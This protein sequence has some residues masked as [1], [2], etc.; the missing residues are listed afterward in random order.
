MAFAA[1]VVSSFNKDAT[2]KDLVMVNKC[3]KLFKCN[4]LVFSF[5]QIN[6][7]QNIS[8][9]CFNDASFANLQI[10]HKQI[11]PIRNVTDSKSLHD[12]VYS[13]KTLTKK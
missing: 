13:T 3:I 7:L 6:D 11:L 8:L 2:V 12:T 5:P 4:E 9:V 10:A 1:S